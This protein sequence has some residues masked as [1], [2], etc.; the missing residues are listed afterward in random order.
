MLPSRRGGVEAQNQ[1][2]RRMMVRSKGITMMLTSGGVASEWQACRPSR[3]DSH[4]RHVQCGWRVCVW[5]E[6][7]IEVVSMR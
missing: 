4:L 7:G 3:R 6:L 2:M 5:A 1:G